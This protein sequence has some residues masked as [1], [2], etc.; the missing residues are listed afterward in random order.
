MASF[1]ILVEDGNSVVKKVKKPTHVRQ[2]FPE[3]W[4]WLDET[5]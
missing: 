4:L 2:N 3:T 1:F 5:V